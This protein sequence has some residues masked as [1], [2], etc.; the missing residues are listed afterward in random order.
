MTNR[1]PVFLL[2]TMIVFSIS[3]TVAFGADIFVGTWKVNIAKSK[4]DPGPAPK[5]PSIT[6]VTAVGDGLKFVQD[7]V[8]GTG[9]KTHGEFTVK[10]DGKDYP[11][12]GTI[13]GKPDPTYQDMISAK[14]IDDYT[15]E[16][17]SKLKNKIIQVQKVVFSKDG[18][19]RTVTQT[20][21]NAQ[22]KPFNN[23][24]I[25]DKQ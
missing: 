24:V 23:T 1:M 25:Y 7:G 4:Y 10:F 19:T 21:T 20:G 13:D 15:F 12:K 9:Q 11:A 16:F 3:A 22:D 6:D 18:K 17:T 5:V 2:V 14:K 8:A